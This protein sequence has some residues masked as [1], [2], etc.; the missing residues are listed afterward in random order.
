MRGAAHRR[1]SDRRGARLGPS[2][3]SRSISRGGERCDCAPGEEKATL[4]PRSQAPPVNTSRGDGAEGRRSRAHAYGR[5]LEPDISTWQKSGPFYL[6]LTGSERVDAGRRYGREAG[7]RRRRADGRRSGALITGGDHVIDLGTESPDQSDEPADTEVFGFRI[8]ADN[9]RTLRPG[10]AYSQVPAARQER[11][12]AGAS[13]L[14][15]PP[16]ATRG[17]SISGPGSLARRRSAMLSR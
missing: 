9:L 5:R 7:G 10:R 1:G 14:R 2:R 12:D 17:V 13:L 4:S 11:S 15:T 6:A 3:P 16:R 8:K